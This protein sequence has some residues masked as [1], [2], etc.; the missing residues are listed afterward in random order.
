MKWNKK[1]VDAGTV[2]RLCE[3][4]KINPV[5]STIF[6]RRNLTEPEDLKYYLTPA[7][8]SFLHNPF[9]FEDMIVFC[10][11]LAKAKKNNESICIFGDRDVDGITSTVLLKQEL[12][13]EGINCFYKLPENDEPYGMTINGIDEAIE[14][15]AHL[16]LTVDCGISNFEEISYA[17]KKGIETIIIDH[18]LSGENQPS[19]L[20]IIDPKVEGSGYPFPFLAGCGVVSKC[21]WAYRFSKTPEYKKT[22]ILLHSSSISGVTIIEAMKMKNLIVVDKVEEEVVPGILKLEDSHLYNFINCGLPI[23]VMDK[24]YELSEL[25]K[26]YGNDFSLKMIDKMPEI[27]RVLPQTKSKSLFTLTEMSNNVR[28]MKVKT[29]GRTLVAIYTA[30][31][32]K[33]Y[34]ELSRDYEPTLDLVALGTVSDLM[35]IMD[36]NRILV[37]RGLKNLEKKTRINF[38]PYLIRQGLVNKPLSTTDIGWKIGPAI[39]ASGRMGHPSVAVEMFLAKDQLEASL[40][41]E[42]LFSFNKERKKLGEEAWNKILP[43]AKK[44]FEMFGTKLIIVRDDSIVRGITG[45]IANRLLKQFNAPSII[46]TSNQMGKL[47]GSMRSFESLNA[48]TFLSRYEDLLIDFGGHSCAAGF[49]LLEENYDELT[50]RISEDIDYFDCPYCEEE[51]SIDVDA[52]LPQAFFTP[53]LIKMVELFE[54][55]GEKNPPLNFLIQGAKIVQISFLSN[56]NLK[57]PCHVR[58][59]IKHGKYQWP[60]I[61]WNAGNKVKDSIFVDDTVDIVF[62]LGKN[63]YMNQESLQLTVLDLKKKG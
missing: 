56:S 15:G 27:N 30:Y 63:Y 16:F 50:C 3:K 4:Y 48:R 6:V 20:G 22:I 44:S 43:Q 40:Y 32:N 45:I 46:V 37:K 52:L 9:Y 10:D 62:R 33:L 5:L 59:T 31:I 42:K 7:N 13:Q 17:S 41:T 24:S 23:L 55:Y 38:Q 11:R 35:P 12:D 1:T 19:A 60:A 28:F 18:H 58:M 21:I 57:A 47:I 36:E 25:K 54:P 2:S 29:E 49:N 53:S 51:A 8:I 26:A 39:N 34:P 14:K 61:F